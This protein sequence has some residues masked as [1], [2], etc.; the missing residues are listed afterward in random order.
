MSKILPGDLDTVA[1]KEY[2]NAYDKYTEFAKKVAALPSESGR[3]VLSERSQNIMD[4]YNGMSDYEEEL[5]QDIRS[6]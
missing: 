6:R 3:Q 4:L 5:P 1:S 2:F